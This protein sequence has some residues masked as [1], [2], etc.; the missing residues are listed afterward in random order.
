MALS[1]VCVCSLK[2][3]IHV[4]IYFCSFVQVQPWALALEMYLWSWSSS[5]ESISNQ[6]KGKDRRRIE[7]DNKSMPHSLDF[8]QLHLSPL[9]LLH[10]PLAPRTLWMSL[11]KQKATCYSPSLNCVSVFA[12]CCPST[13]HYKNSLVGMLKKN[14]KISSCCIFLFTSHKLRNWNGNSIVYSQVLHVFKSAF[15]R[16]HRFEEPLTISF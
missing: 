9:T 11:C 10:R 3:Y 1:P 14:H 5:C 12:V 16:L 15:S 6:P 7:K 2:F 13:I 8:T 4:H